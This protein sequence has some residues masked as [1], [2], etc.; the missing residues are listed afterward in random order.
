MQRRISDH[1]H[2]VLGA[3][4]L[5]LAPL[6]LAESNAVEACLEN[7]VCRLQACGSYYIEPP[8]KI[9]DADQP[10]E[11][12][13][14][15][16]SAIK[17]DLDG[18]Q[19]VLEGDVELSKSDLLL[20]T[21]RAQFN[22]STQK[23]VLEGGVELRQPGIV[24]TGERADLNLGGNLGSLQNAEFISYSS[25]ARAEAALIS[26]V[27]EQRMHLKNASYTQCRPDDEAWR[28]Q[29]GDIKLDY[30]SGRGVAKNAQ[31][32]VYNVPVAWVPWIN[33][34]VDSR[35]ATGVLWPS[36]G[37]S[38]GGLDISVP[39]YLN[40]AP[41]ADATLTPRHLSDHGTALEAEAR[42]LN[43]RGDL[44]LGG[45][46]LKDDE[47]TDEDRWVYDI[48][49]DGRMNEN[50]GTR[51]R[52]SKVSDQ[53]Y[54]RDLGIA[55]LAV[56][57]A[58]HLEQSSAVT[59]DSKHWQA[60][61]STEQYQTLSGTDKP[62]RK[63]PQVQIRHRPTPKNFGLE[64]VL[65]VDYTQFEHRD[66]DV[67]GTEIP[68][69]SR[70]YAEA[71]VR[72]PIHGRAGSITAEVKQRSLTYRLE[73]IPAD[74]DQ[75]PSA[76]A[77]QA[78]IDAR[79]EL[80]RR[81]DNWIQSVQPRLYYLY[82]EHAQQEAFPDF[83]TSRLPFS[84]QQLFRPSR[85]A[86]RDR[87][88]DADQLTLGVETAFRRAGDDHE[89]L[90]IGVGQIA[91]FQDREVQAQVENPT[92]SPIPDSAPETDDRSP[93]AIHFRAQPY[94]GSDTGGRQWYEGEIV[95]DSEQNE[96][97]R[98]HL[99][100]AY[101]QG[102]T[103]YNAGLGYRRPQQD[104]S[105]IDR[106]VYQIDLSGT[107]RVSER[108]KLFARAHYDLEDDR[109]FENLIGIEYQSCCWLS[110]VVWQR[111]LEPS[112]ENGVDTTSADNAFLLEFQLKGLGGLGN[113]ASSQLRESI[114]GYEQN[115]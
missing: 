71:G 43:K 36:L 89:T 55:N 30:E 105:S 4:A 90:R 74:A 114:H 39:V 41:N 111:A 84:Y 48:K 10:F 102:E 22:R 68:T 54:F 104:D 18:D 33:F 113:K 76:S 29:A 15:Y 59:F 58:S 86:G 115:Y 45:A 78:S 99:G 101:R 61:L 88:D 96:I 56:K 92:T 34:P 14:L 24:M 2:G 80:E 66:A 69:G 8:L 100:W 112:V 19:V 63:L 106:P 13:P 67:P 49:H 9:R 110:R 26:R 50:L 87:L 25:G 5:S 3:V 7:T 70:V 103:V 23:L 11:N 21:G 6:A 57:R 31:L 42:Y 17:T 91:Y 94:A 37:T 95:W 107:K 12:A 20:R 85:F 109:A 97:D 83:D 1:F 93:I 81:G 75:S 64:P 28:L 35:R 72:V 32:R 44:Q 27:A 16:G 47:Q 79:L 40:I 53:D 52:W 51:I 38:D 108:T 73:D 82:A 46:L 65:K 60:E 77:A 98:G 62:Y